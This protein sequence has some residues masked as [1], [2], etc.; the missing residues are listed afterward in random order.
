MRIALQI[1]VN[2]GIMENTAKYGGRRVDIMVARRETMQLFGNR[3]D[4]W[5]AGFVG[6]ALRCSMKATHTHWDSI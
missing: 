3:K 6:K 1:G 4:L 2:L 5:E